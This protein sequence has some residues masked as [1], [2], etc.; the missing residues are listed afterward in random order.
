VGA[1]APEVRAA[2]ATAR[3]TTPRE[4]VRQLQGDLDT[5]VATALKKEPARRYASVE[6]LADDLA[7]YR[8]GH[9]IRARADS[10]GYR[11]RKFVG[12]NRLA[13]ASA[14]V[15]V[16][17]LL[18]LVAQVVQQSTIAAQERD[19]ARAERDAAREVTE[20]L[21]TLFEAD[22]YAAADVARDQ[23][24]VGDFLV[25]SE[26]TVRRELNDRPELRARLFTLLARLNANLGRLD[27]ALALAEEAVPERRRAL[28][29]AHPEVAESLNILGTALQERG[30]YDRAE[31]VFREALAIRE[32]ALGEVHEDTA[33][34]VNNLAVLLAIRARP[35][36]VAET[37]RLERKGLAL[38]RQ[39]FGDRH[40]DTAQS[41]NNL[42]V[43]L[44]QQRRAGD[45]E[46]AAELLAEALAIR[47]E[48]LGAD[49]PW[50]ANTRSNLANVLL[51]TARAGESEALF[52]EAIRGWSAS[53][54]PQHVRVASGWTGLSKALERSGDLSGAL[55][56]ARQA[57]TIEAASLPADHPNVARGRA[58]VAE[59]E[60]RPAAGDNG[61][62]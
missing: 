57:A 27:P 23:L 42:A 41:L 61:T 1:V 2:L 15:A 22:P 24:S 37:E 60:A 11:L 21:V 7:R 17:V 55:E 38:R 16:V 43:F 49:H 26:A 52:R 6:R 36:D 13:V 54:G 14:S 19:S 5:V 56:A 4:L 47:E 62:P 45:L 20:V 8:A 32:A 48:A 40:L 25:A 51:L 35:E 44:Y 29:A 12:R 18:V 28:G 34:S 3:S 33:E 53:L 46:A 59:L 9:T 10:A 39:V 58:R 31:T 50:V 30:E